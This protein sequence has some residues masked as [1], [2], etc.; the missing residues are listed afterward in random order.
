MARSVLDIAIRIVKTQGSEENR[1]LIADLKQT[2][3][4]L[5]EI[6]M[7][8]GA[9]AG[10]GV[11]LKKA[12]DLAR[13]GAQIELVKTRFDR[14][15]TSIGTTSDA[16]MS[17]LRT[18]TRGLYSDTELATSAM[19]LMG[20]GLAKTH[21]EAVRLAS[22]SSA[23]N[24]N[25]N[26]LVLTLTNQTTMRFDALGVSVD[27]F[28]EK[29]AEL[30]AAGMDANAAFTEAFLQQAE[31]QIEKVGH[32][33]D[34]GAGEFLKME[35]HWKNLTDS[36]KTNLATAFVPLLKYL[37]D[38]REAS[39][40]YGS[41]LSKVA[42]QQGMTTD[43]L[44]RAMRTVSDSQDYYRGLVAEYQRAEQ[45]G[46]SWERSLR[47]QG[48]ALSSTSSEVQ[49]LTV[50]LEDQSRANQDMMGLI[51]QLQSAYDSYQS[52]LGEVNLKYEDAKYVQDL[53]KQSKTE[54]LAEAR[55]GTIT[56]EEYNTQIQ[57]LNQDYRDGTF[58]AQKQQEAVD[59]LA[60]EH[61][62]ASQRIAFSLLQQKA[63][64]DGLTDAEFESLLKI[65]QQW[66]IID[67]KV[68]DSALLMD[69]QMGNIAASLDSPI[70]QAQTFLGQLKR[71]REISGEEFEFFVNIYS[72]GAFPSIPGGGGSGGGVQYSLLSG[73]GPLTPVTVVGDAPGGAWTPY[74]EVIIGNRV[75]SNEESKSLRDAGLLGS[76]SHRWFGGDIASDYPFAST[77]LPGGIV[78]SEI[79]QSSQAAGREELRVSQDI[80]QNNAIQVDALVNSNMAIV[81]EQKET[82][83][84]LKQQQNTFLRGIVAGLI[85]VN[86]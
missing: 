46:R 35:A 38:T 14:L 49:D 30:E 52:K 84:L 10:V 63:A 56:W 66:G 17:D 6:A 27:G 51:G 86:P 81:S 59:A 58:A 83:K 43:E 44:Q 57:Q 31:A 40:A 64:V 15:S 12:F 47:A 33:A 50:S 1:K 26:Q 13:E 3:F 16:L 22:I 67:E 80:Q 37:N 60:Q 76:A 29:V 72:S 41:V 39:E 70:D 61:E 34:T 36:I 77:T 71:L 21:D 4:A 11:T 25:M 19:D 79:S 42:Q 68:A 54:L 78:A 7:M 32:A 48:V 5:G 23:L 82:N 53:Y 62:K 20:L 24:M 69:Q 28:K 2:K 45:Y 85:Q 74:T 55:A 75:F 65:G 9:I 8:G 18:A 73:G